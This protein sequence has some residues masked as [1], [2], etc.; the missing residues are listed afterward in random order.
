M[1][2]E[3]VNAKV[4]SD[5]ARVTAMSLICRAP[6]ASSIQLR[7]TP[8]DQGVQH[9]RAAR[10][11]ITENLEIALRGLHARSGHGSVAD[12]RRLL[13]ENERFVAREAPEVLEEVRGIAEGAGL[14][15]QD[16]LMLSL[17][18]FLVWD[19]LP[20][21]CTQILISPPATGGQTLLAKTRDLALG[22]LRHVV[23]HRTTVDG[24]SLAEVHV[25]GSVTWPGSG[26]SDDGVAFST[27]GVWSARLARTIDHADG[28]WLLPNAHLLLRGARSADEFVVLAQGQPRL[29]SMNI[30]VADRRVGIAVELTPDRAATDR[31]HDG[32]IVRTN[33]FTDPELAP[34]GP[35]RD[36]NASS[37]RRAQAAHAAVRRSP[38][39]WDGHALS[40]L[41]AS[42]DGYPNDSICRHRLDGEGS[43]TVYASI[44]DVTHGTFTVLLD[45][46]CRAL[47]AAT[48]P[49]Q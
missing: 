44:A 12:T 47:G 23:L 26:M 5:K 20:L 3:R 14:Q 8:G 21:D 30:V 11:A 4:V 49:R 25:A 22:R 9:G 43:D 46:P 29:T 1:Q 13:A 39:T 28:A 6:A 18:V 37:Y 24:R 10:Q 15:Y 40:R 31:G 45:N 32:V 41:L 48:T 35:R 38:G 34:L 19:Y 33:H 27:S 16:V 7:G 2:F 17:P 42:H 36:E